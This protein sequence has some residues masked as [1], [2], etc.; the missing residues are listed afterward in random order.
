M[1]KRKLYWIIAAALLL[2]I[3]I[4]VWPKLN[5]SVKPQQEETSE[6]VKDTIPY[7]TEG[8]AAMASITEYVS[9]VCDETSAD[10]VEKEDR[11]AVFDFDGT[12]YGE[13]YPTYFDTWLFIHR[14][15][16]DET[17]QPSEEI[18]EYAQSM[19]D[20]FLNRLPEPDS[21]LSTAQCC[22]ELFKGMSVDEYREYIRNFMKEETVG[23]NGM[24]FAEG[25]YLPMVSLVEY[26][27]AHDFTVF[28]S[29][30]SER[31]MVRELI[32]GTLDEWIPSYQII[33][34]DFTLEASGQGSKSGKSYTLKADDEI[35]MEGNLSLKN[36]KAN[37]VF[38]IIQEI[39]NFPLLVFGN[40]SGDLAMAQ[41]ALQNGGR[42]YMLLCDDTERDY[43]NLETAASFKED[44][45]KMGLETVS[46]KDDFSLIYA[47]GFEKTE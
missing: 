21:D 8:S 27:D 42:G 20:A 18:K 15:L 19:E 29:S 41:Y 46:M 36:Q 25:F 44:C 2:V 7:W 34:S 23:F 4:A 43:G 39:G 22:A 47:Q 37:K 14:A 12:L 13:L 26:L 5:P 3:T 28:I 45:L 10:Y 24:T 32:E 30:G 17:C 31:T 1:M 40:S 33:G 16:H 6:I 11:I 35:I 9:S 38:N